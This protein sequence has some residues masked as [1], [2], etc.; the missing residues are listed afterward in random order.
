[1]AYRRLTI[2]L[3]STSTTAPLRVVPPPP[4]IPLDTDGFSRPNTTEG[5]LG[6]TSGGLAW[7]TNRF[8]IS[9]SRAIVETG[10]PG[11]MYR[12]VVDTGRTDIEVHATVYPPSGGPGAGLAVRGGNLPAAPFYW[13]WGSGHE[14][15]QNWTIRR[16]DG[17]SN[18]DVLN[19][20][21]PVEEGPY[22]MGLIVKGSSVTAII[23]GQTFS[24]TD[25]NVVG[26]THVGFYAIPTNNAGTTT[27]TS[28]FDNFAIYEPE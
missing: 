19:T 24:V 28:M 13:L 26:G 2:P 21:I 17:G 5:N 27:A 12:A 6:E 11:Q 9:D 15:T 10:A 4:R 8:R 7:E 25:S 14:A 3:V 23:D 22:E 1:M 20:G 18:V 16:R